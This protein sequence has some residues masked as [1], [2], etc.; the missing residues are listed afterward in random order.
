MRMSTSA[1]PGLI[2]QAMADPDP[3]SMYMR[4]FHLLQALGQHE[5]ALTM[6]AKALERCSLY[7]LAAPVAPTIR[8]LALMVPGDSRDNAPLDYVVENIP[9]RLDLLYL[10]P[11]QE[12][13]ETIPDHDVAIVAI[14]E[15]TRNQ[16]LLAYAEALLADWP[17]P[18]LNPPRHV[19]RC[20]RD[21]AG[22]LLQHIPGLL[23][24]AMQRVTRGHIVDVRFPATIRPVDSHSGLGLAKLANK[25]E[26][27]AY[28]SEHVDA[29]FYLAEY[30]DYRGADG[31][32]RKY[33]IALID[34][35]PYICHLA[36][37]DVWMVHYATSGMQ[38]SAERR[39]EEAAAMA[40]FERDFVVRHRAA[41]E[42]I[43]E[44]LELDYVILD[45]AEMRDGRLLLF[46]VD[47]GGWIHADDPI[48]I[49]PY[50]PPVMQ[51]VFDAFL[52][53]LERRATR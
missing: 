36:I 8:L 37:A 2:E 42:A 3:A 12:L 16:P 44:R 35:R 14:R 43:A 19:L 49:Y 21:V 40:S 30:V 10:S 18:V 38:L 52:Y 50:K 39:A 23:V 32:F 22:R 11:D 34:N 28:L 15:S 13:P 9:V 4:M 29:E 6:Q 48:D 25:E 47:T 7:R 46:E 45:C 24:P 27:D 31:L 5:L 17:R 41:L 26:L 53:M 33:R 51:Q 1:L 20:A